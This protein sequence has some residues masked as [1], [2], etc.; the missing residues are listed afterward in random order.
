MQSA[1]MTAGE[2]WDAVMHFAEKV[3]VDKVNGV[4]LAVENGA[5]LERSNHFPTRIFARPAFVKKYKKI[6][7]Q[8]AFE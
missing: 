7:F 2:T 5:L 1:E 8:G 4:R 6:K 3:F